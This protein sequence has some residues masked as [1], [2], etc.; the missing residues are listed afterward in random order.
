MINK[1]QRMMKKKTGRFMGTASKSHNRQLD[2]RQ[3][4]GSDFYEQEEDNCYIFF[5]KI[6]QSAAT[7]AINEN[8]AMKLPVTY[9]KNGWVVRE[10]PGGNVER[11]AQ[12]TGIA[13]NDR[14]K[15]LTKGT[16]IHAKKRT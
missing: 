10:M 16:V 3:K 9:M 1:C 8:K 15:K 6:G 13:T 14:E 4:G 11:I 7:N 2:L 5:S 12:V